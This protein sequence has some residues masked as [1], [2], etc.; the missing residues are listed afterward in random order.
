DAVPVAVSFLAVTGGEAPNRVA[1]CGND[2]G[3]HAFSATAG[4]VS[5]R[6]HSVG[7]PQYWIEGGLGLGHLISL[8]TES[9]FEHPPLRGHTGLSVRVST[10]L[11]WAA[12]DNFLLGGELAW[13]RWSNVER[14]AG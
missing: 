13:M 1:G 9:A 5:V 4:V 14:A 10:G 8:Q 11:R 3:S 7:A 2:R 6:F 12:S